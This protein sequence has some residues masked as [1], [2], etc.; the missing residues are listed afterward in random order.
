V[1]NIKMDLR[2]I[3]WDG[4]AWIGTSGGLLWIRY[5][6]YGFHEML[7][8][9]WVGAQ[10]AASQEG[11]S[12]VSKYMIYISYGPGVRSLIPSRVKIFS[13]TPHP[14]SYPMGTG[15]TVAGAWSVTVHIHLVPRSR[16]M[17]LTST[18]PPVT[19]AEP[20][21]AWTVIARSVDVIIGS[22]AASGKDV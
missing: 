13:P 10:L 7:G 11:L 18:V 22:N 15:G 8:S 3:G 6:T 17:E 4:V 14:A 20:S 12:S 1:D 19:V 9:S 16:T 5:W 21:K 2:E